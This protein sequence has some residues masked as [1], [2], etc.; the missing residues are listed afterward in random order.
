MFNLAKR[1]D[2]VMI[3]L[4]PYFRD[5]LKRDD[6]TKNWIITRTIVEKKKR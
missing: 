4:L 2:R 6:K 1:I 5:N 3:V